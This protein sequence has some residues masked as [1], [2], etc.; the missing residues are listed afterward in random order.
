MHIGAMSVQRFCC[1]SKQ[2]LCSPVTTYTAVLRRATD[3]VTTSTSLYP[4]SV[5]IGH[6]KTGGGRHGTVV[7]WPGL[8]SWPFTTNPLFAA[9]ATLKRSFR[10]WTVVVCALIGANTSAFNTYS[11]P[12]LA[13]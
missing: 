9:S 11:W 10:F 4:I 8:S 3:S 7:S 12:C 13:P 1:R 2:A 5:A 6:H